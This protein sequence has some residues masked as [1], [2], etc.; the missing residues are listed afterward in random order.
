MTVVYNPEA[1]LS[2][3]TPVVGSTG[4]FTTVSVTSATA[5]SFLRVTPV[6]VASLPAAATAGAGARATVNDAL[7]P[8]Y[9]SAVAGGG[10]VVIGVISTGSSWNVG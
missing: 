3:T 6:A 8:A 1:A 5:S 10:A 4:T 9:G 2:A 7:T